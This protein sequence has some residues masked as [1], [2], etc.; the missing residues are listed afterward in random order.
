M[1]IHQIQ[2]KIENV[3]DGPI[4]PM[5]TMASMVATALCRIQTPKSLI[6]NFTKCNR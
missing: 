3:K 1:R 2:M 6:L 5:T 4:G